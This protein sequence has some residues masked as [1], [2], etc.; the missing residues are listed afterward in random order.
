MDAAMDAAR[1][2]LTMHTDTAQTDAPAAILAALLADGLDTTDAL[3]VAERVDDIA[4]ALQMARHLNLRGAAAR[5]AE[6]AAFANPPA[7]HTIGKPINGAVRANVLV[8]PDRKNRDMATVAVPGTTGG[9]Y[10]IGARQIGTAARPEF[11]TWGCACID[12]ERSGREC[13]HLRAAQDALHAV[14]WTRHGFPRVPTLA[15][16]TL[17]PTRRGRN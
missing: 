9:A 15:G 14:W 6:D 7:A 10:Q 5:R 8:T 16:V 13:K 1:R 12:H 2:R 3:F 11:L 4:S 17:T